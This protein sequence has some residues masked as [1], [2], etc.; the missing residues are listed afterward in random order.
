MHYSV[1]KHLY[2]CAAIAGVLLSACSSG[3]ASNSSANDTKADTIAPALTLGAK[4]AFVRPSGLG[5]NMQ[6]AI[7]AGGCFWCVES[8]FEKLDGVSEVISGYT[9]GMLDNP[10]YEL[11]SYEE[12][13]HYEAAMIIYDPDVVSYRELIDHYWMTIDPTDPTGQFCDKGSSYRTAIFTTPGQM[14]EAEASKEVIVNSGQI[15]RV[16]TPVLPATTF[17]PAED[18]HQDYYKKKPV[19]YK[20]YRFGCRRDARLAELWSK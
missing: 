3:A 11:V 17:Y 12:T 10:T 8:D 13:G 1:M 16:V 2:I 9:G 4:A 15:E 5:P 14:T 6:T 19:R 7:V 20:S 18:Y